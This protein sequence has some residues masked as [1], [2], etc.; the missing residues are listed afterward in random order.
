MSRIIL[1]TFIAVITIASATT[2]YAAQ[3]KVAANVRTI[4]T[5]AL[6]EVKLTI[7]TQGE[8][9][10]T[11]AG[12]LVLP[13]GIAIPV[14]VRDGGTI[15]NFWIDKPAVADGS[16]QFSGITPGGFTGAGTLFV[17]VTLAKKPGNGTI[18]VANAKALRN[19]G[20]GSAASASVT[21]AHIAVSGF[22]TTSPTGIPAVQDSESPEPFTPIVTRD[23]AL[24]NGAYV[25]VFAT[26]DKKSG[27]DHYEIAERR[28]LRHFFF[29]SLQWRRADSPYLL[30]D[31]FLASYVYVRAVDRAGNE[32]LATLSPEH[33]PLYYNE[34]FLFGILMLSA[35]LAFAWRMRMRHDRRTT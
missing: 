21:S 1:P 13:S 5:G 19:D 20:A 34:N 32:R 16:V 4:Q 35:L 22:A 30:S 8:S 15:V 28:G 3:F 7:D 26:Q 11:F 10:N 14:E 25:L 24:M 29:G 33:L 12:R 31:Q 18:T 23:P 6:F 9:I 27:V 17:L 2:A